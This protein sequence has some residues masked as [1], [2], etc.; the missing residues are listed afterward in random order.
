MHSVH[1]AA[2]VVEHFPAVGPQLVLHPDRKLPPLFLLH[3]G[4]LEVWGAVWLP[5]A[6]PGFEIA[7]QL[8]AQP[9]GPRPGN[10]RLARPL[11]SLQVEPLRER[12]PPLFFGRYPLDA[13]TQ[14]S[15]AMYT[16]RGSVM[17]GG[18]WPG[19]A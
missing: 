18:Y 6:V 7:E 2:Q 4:G 17:R 14:V 11:N 19:P 15:E 5:G 13:V 8:L 1:P 16:R 3:P 12:R 9:L 10:R